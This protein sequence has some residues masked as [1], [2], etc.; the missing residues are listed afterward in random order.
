[1]NPSQEIR[2]VVPLLAE[3]NLRYGMLLSVLPQ[4]SAEYEE[5]EGPFWRN[6]RREGVFVYGR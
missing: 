3:L 6:V 2:R 5:G 4:S 1:M